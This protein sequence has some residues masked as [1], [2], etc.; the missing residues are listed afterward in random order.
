MKLPDVEISFGDAVDDDDGDD[1]ERVLRLHSRSSPNDTSVSRCGLFCW[2]EGEPQ[3][4]H[5]C[6]LLVSLGVSLAE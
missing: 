1:V 2:K 6:D 4:L 3:R 5:T